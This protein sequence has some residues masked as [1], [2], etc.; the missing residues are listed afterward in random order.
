M[1]AEVFVL[2]NE[3]MGGSG[4]VPTYQPRTLSLRRSSL[5]LFAPAPGNRTP[6]A[7]IVFFGN[8]I[9]FWKPHRRLAAGLA[10][11]GYAV[12]GVDIRPVLDGSARDT[13]QHAAIVRMRLDSI[14]GGAYSE[15]GS[16]APDES[17]IV[18]AT[19]VMSAPVPL[20]LAGHS[21]GAELALWAAANMQLPELRGVVAISPG[22]RTHLTVSASDI[23]MTSEPVGPGSFAVSDF[24]HSVLTERPDVRMAIVRGSNDPLRSADSALLVA[25]DSDIRRFGVP[26]AG[27]SM[28]RLAL[29]GLV[30]RR[31]LDWVLVTPPNAARS[32]SP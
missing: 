1:C 6:R 13:A 22:S 4:E 21:L 5:E 18:P 9:G 26:M 10:R 16:A 29:A 3:Q 19:P 20:V 23:L 31:A 17:N 7:V 27:H 30:V 14:I 24:A 8:D 11:D 2:F 15:F 25:G 12:V 32:S 28:K